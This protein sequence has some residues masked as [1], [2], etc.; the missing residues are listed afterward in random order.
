MRSETGQHGSL[1]CSLTSVQTL[2]I[3]V[4]GPGQNC[5]VFI[6]D[7]CDKKSVHFQLFLCSVT[8]LQFTLSQNTEKTQLCLVSNSA[9]ALECIKLNKY[10]RR[11]SGVRVPHL[12]PPTKCLTTRAESVRQCL[13]V[14]RI[15]VCLVGCVM[16][17]AS[18]A[19]ACVHTAKHRNC[20]GMCISVS[21]LCV[22][23][24]LL[25]TALVSYKSAI[26]SVSVVF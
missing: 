3:R 13:A 8:L 23:F 1:I 20:V 5:V 19:F 17:S 9:N 4:R 11:H 7:Y 12:W 15:T 10:H 26:L 25:S 6:S 21:V 24:A 16:L 18:K 2:I 14:K 22:S